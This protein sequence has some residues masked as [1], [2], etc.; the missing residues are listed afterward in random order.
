MTM[1]ITID[2]VHTEQV[3]T[4]LQQQERRCPLDEVAK[5]CPNLTDDQFFLAID[6]LTR[7]GQVCLTMDTNRTYWVRVSG[8]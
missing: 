8:S 1:S 7:S 4:A 6:S 3:L 5:L 2:Q